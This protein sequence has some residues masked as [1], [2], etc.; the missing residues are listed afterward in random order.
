MP[1]FTVVRPCGNGTS[2]LVQTID[3]DG[4]PNARQEIEATESAFTFIT[5][6]GVLMNFGGTERMKDKKAEKTKI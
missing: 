2:P 1:F 5:L 4:K 3:G 6:S